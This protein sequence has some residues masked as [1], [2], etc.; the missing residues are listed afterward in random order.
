MVASLAVAVADAVVAE[1]NARAWSITFVA[2]RRI[3]PEREIGTFTIP[4]VTVVPRSQEFAIVARGH[5]REQVTI[6]IGIQH[7]LSGDFDAEVP[8]DIALVDEIIKHFLGRRLSS[9]PVVCISAANDPIYSP[10]HLREM[11]LV[12]TIV[13]L[14]FDATDTMAEAPLKP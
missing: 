3:L 10:E 5:V 13:S 4:R 6:D 11:S 9:P 1:L 2:E 12:T 8:T 7:H 14:T